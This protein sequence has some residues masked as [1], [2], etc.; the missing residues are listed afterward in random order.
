MKFSGCRI[1][2]KGGERCGKPLVDGKNYCIE[3][4]PN[5]KHPQITTYS[6]KNYFDG[7]QTVKAHEYKDY[8]QSPEWKQKAER[9]KEKNPNCSLC[10]RKGVLHVHHR[11]YVRCGDEREGDLV[12]LC[13]DCHKMFHNFY[14]YDGKVGTFKLV[15]KIK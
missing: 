12:V 4:A 6:L 9:E 5:K 13:A 8:L 11:T 10:N 14:E 1:K 3:H 2:V 15:K 7:N